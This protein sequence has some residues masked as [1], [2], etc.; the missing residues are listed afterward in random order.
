MDGLRDG[1]TAAGAERMAA[2]QTPQREPSPL[3]QTVAPDGF[4]AVLGA[5]GKVA[6]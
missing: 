3:C 1:V 6:T 4:V 5:G 2:E